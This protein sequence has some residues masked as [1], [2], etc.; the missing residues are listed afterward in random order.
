MKAQWPAKRRRSRRV[1]Q[2]AGLV[3]IG[4][5]GS[6]CL[7][8][9]E[10]PEPGSIHVTAEPNDATARGF[11]T[12]D[13]WSVRFDRFVT[14]LGDI[15]LHSESGENGGPLSAGSCTEYAETHYDWLFDFTVAEREKVGLVFGLG[16]CSVEWSFRP[17]SHDSVLGPGGTAQDILFMRTEGSD[18][19]AEQQRVALVAQGQAE[20]GGVT[21]RF[22]WAFRH[23]YEVD[24]CPDE[25]SGGW[26]S[27]VD[28]RGGDALTLRI[29]VRGEELFR[30]A[31]LD[32]APLH[33]DLFAG[34]D[35][36]GDGVITLE[37]LGE[38]DAPEGSI[39]SDVEPPF[40]SGTDG[41]PP[42]LGDVVYG[43]LLPRITRLAGGGACN[44]DLDSRWR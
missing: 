30:A 43:L 42:S 13:G 9:D 6:G 15:R 44:A 14:A 1:G 19:Y 18:A 23:W 32:A 2:G 11:T 39:P 5:V 21:K 31:P 33:F 35:A 37:E 16:R 28:L 24:E 29:E 4:L 34:A 3:A 20:R 41:V 12:P 25:S 38:V 17:P 8:G 26:M 10:R 40:G 36:D 7:P 22:D 27:V